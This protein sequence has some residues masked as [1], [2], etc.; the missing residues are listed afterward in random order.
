MCDGPV[1]TLWIE[2]LNTVLD[3]NKILTLPNN[4]RIPMT[5][6]CKLVLEVENL[7]NASP[8]TVSRVGIVY[9]SEIE[10]GWEPVVNVWCKCRTS[11][12]KVTTTGRSEE[13]DILKGLLQKYLQQN[14]MFVNMYK[15]GGKIFPVM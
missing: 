12:Q 15:V 1:D 2:S 9:I 7:K 10:L 5:D 13:S 6:N 8:A 14:N 4:D 3:D 11:S